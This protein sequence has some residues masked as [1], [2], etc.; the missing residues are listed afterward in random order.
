M[1]ALPNVVDIKWLIANYQSPTVKV[2]DGSYPSPMQPDADSRKDWLSKRIP[3]AIFFDFDN[4]V[5]DMHSLLPHMLPSETVFSH[6]VSKLGIKNDDILVV[7]DSQGLFSAARVWWMF[8]TMGHKNVAVLSGGLPAWEKEGGEIESGEPSQREQSQ[9]CASFNPDWVID[10]QTLLKKIERKQVN[11]VDV[12]P[13]ER[14]SAR[15]KEPREGIR[16]GHMPDAKNLPFPYLIEGGK[17]KDKEL[18]REYLE[19]VLSSDLQN[20]AS[21]GSGVTACILALSALHALDK[22][23]TVFDGSWTEWGGNHDLPIVVDTQ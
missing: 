13:E 16:S 11:V 14:F 12:R 2:L 4:E 1:D 8:K 7:Y 6:E 22:Q 15:V 23:V 9:Y 18:L 17:L 3:S 21:C 10:S 5:K 20:V 19:P